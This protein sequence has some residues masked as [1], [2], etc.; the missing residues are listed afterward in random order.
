MEVVSAVGGIDNSLSEIESL[1]Q[2][3]GAVWN[4][5]VAEHVSE[6]LLAS[7]VTQCNSFASE[8]HSMVSI[9]Q[10]RRSEMEQLASQ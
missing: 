3:I 4:D 2:Q 10:M 7:I 1:M 8:M 5:R 9:I 6:E